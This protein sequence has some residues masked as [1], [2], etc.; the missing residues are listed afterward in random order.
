LIVDPFAAQLCGEEGLAIGRALEAEGRAHSAIVV[1]TRILDERIAASVVADNIR[2]IAL[3]GSGLDA[4]AFRLA[5]PRGTRVLE[6]DFAETIAWKRARLPAVPTDVTHELHALDLRQT[7]AV[8]ALLAGDEPML[9]VLEGV[10]PYLERPDADVLLTA[11]AAR[12]GR[13]TVLC[14]VGGGAWGLAAARRTAR[15]VAARGAPFLTRFSHP[16]AWLESLG[17]SVTANVSFVDWDEAR[18]ERRFTTPWT[19]RILPGYRDAAR[20]LEAVSRG[21]L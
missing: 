16:A 19:S 14:D 6:A 5:L 15:V 3:F 17:Y 10:L 11:I 7:S 20:V 13:V 21:A 2:T 8:R 1:R 9:V 18:T 12:R 4:R